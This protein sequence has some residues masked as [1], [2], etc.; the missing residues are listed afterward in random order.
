[1]KSKSAG[2]LILLL[3]ISQLLIGQEALKDGY[4]KL[5]YGNNLISSEG[6]IREGKP[7]GKWISYHINGKIKSEGNRRNFQL[8]SIWKFW[9]EQGFLTEEINYL[10][11]KRSG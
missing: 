1:M 6:M 11:G 9:D 3:L 2:L 5:Y 10:D 7:D 8:D 4:N